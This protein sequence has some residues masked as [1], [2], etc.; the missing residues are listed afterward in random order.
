MVTQEGFWG[1]GGWQKDSQSI[2][3]NVLIPSEGLL[4][5]IHLQDNASQQTV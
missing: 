5:E 2:Q 4:L 1:V 3:K